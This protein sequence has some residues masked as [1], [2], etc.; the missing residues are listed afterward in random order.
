MAGVTPGPERVRIGTLNLREGQPVPGVAPSSWGGGS[1]AA[2]LADQGLDVLCLQEAPFKDGKP[3][4]LVG[5]IVRTSGLS[6]SA[7][8]LLSPS[9]Y[10]PGRES[11]LVTLTRLPAKRSF[12]KRF[13]NPRLAFRRGDV[14]LTTFD[15]GVVWVVLQ[16]GEHELHVGNLH[17][18]PFHNFGRDATDERFSRVWDVVRETLVSGPGRHTVL[19][20]DFNVDSRKLAERLPGLHHTVQGANTTRRLT[21][22]DDITFTAGFSL[23]SGPKIVETTSDHHLCVAELRWQE[24]P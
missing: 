14:E 12:A 5:D 20:G 6:L 15:K 10:T 22:V 24:L 21:S 13:P 19:A 8:L 11:G 1:L 7:S 2:L 18:F 16:A 17:V 9:A 4:E 3:D 23:A